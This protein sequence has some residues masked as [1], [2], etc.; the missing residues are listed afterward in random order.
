MSRS[1]LQMLAPAKLNL[2]LHITGRR[3]D[4]Y[5][6]LQTVFQLLDYGDELDFDTDPAG[7]MSLHI[8]EESLFRPV[9]LEGNLVLAAA[10]ALRRAAGNPALG[11]SIRL[12]K[13][14]PMGAG[15][16]GGSS[17][18][19][20]TL[21][22]LNRLW[23]LDFDTGTLLAIGRELGADVPVFVGGK[24]AWAEGTGERL[25]PLEL[26]LSWYL[27]LT[28]AVRVSTARVFS[29]QN[30]TRNSAPI[31]MQEFM[32]G[33]ARN[34]CEATTCELYP[35][36]KRILQWLGHFAEARMTGTG[37]SVFAA[38]ADR[39]SAETVLRQ[40]PSGSS[41]FVARGMSSQASPDPVT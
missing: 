26:P 1:A 19:A 20:A 28:P 11:A 39:A 33:A 7:G 3:A 25:E 4:G 12:L 24:T 30:L 29:Q 15:L 32:H 31:T 38:F 8:S 34:D 21:L 2:F 14:L 37:S 10:T 9:P 23:Q 6:S 16:G 40:R 18:A 27:V 35:E 41:G 5:H 17:N 22:A 13:R 36:V